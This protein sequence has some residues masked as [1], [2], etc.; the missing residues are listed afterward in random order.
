MEEFGSKSEALRYLEFGIEHGQ[1]QSCGN[2]TL[3]EQL[4]MIH[5]RSYRPSCRE[6]SLGVNDAYRAATSTYCPTDCLFFV[7]K[8]EHAANQKLVARQQSIIQSRRSVRNA[9]GAALLAPLRYF[10]KLP[11]LVQSLLIIL[12]IV[13]LFPQFKNTI[14]EILKAL[15]S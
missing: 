7:T 4:D 14:V 6:K 12:L 2:L 8:E 1:Y 11:A 3:T 5:G 15:K 9:V 13:W 10:Q